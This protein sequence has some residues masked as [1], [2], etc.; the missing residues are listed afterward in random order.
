MF[1]NLDKVIAI[2][3]FTVTE[4]ESKITFPVGTILKVNEN[5]RIAFRPYGI[6]M[7]LPND[8]Y[9]LYKPFVP[10]FKKGDKVRRTIEYCKKYFITPVI[11]QILTVKDDSYIHNNEEF[12]YV[13]E[14]CCGLFCVRNLELIPFTPKFRKGDKVRQTKE[15]CDQCFITGDERTKILTIRED[16]HISGDSEI[17]YTEERAGW[18][19]ITNLEFIPFEPA[20]KKG[21]IIKNKHGIWEVAEDSFMK[22]NEEF[23]PLFYTL[24]NKKESIQVKNDF[25]LLKVAP[26]EVFK[27]S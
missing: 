18:F 25:S 4:C 1:K 9:E 26:F 22:D 15:Y 6:H 10:K 20:L 13:E 5:S 12:C 11:H 7:W 14:E 16:S 19:Y 21:Q 24:S 2:K 27:K 17:C 3:E 8:C 23:V